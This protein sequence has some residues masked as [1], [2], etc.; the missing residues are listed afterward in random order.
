LV[1]KNPAQTKAITLTK[2]KNDKLDSQILVQ[3][4]RNPG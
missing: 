4:G 3:L 2:N 1:E